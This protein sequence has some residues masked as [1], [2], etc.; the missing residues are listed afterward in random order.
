MEEEK[1]GKVYIGNDGILHIMVPELVTEEDIWEILEEIKKSLGGT[2]G[3]TK[4]LIHMKTTSVIKSSVFR[5][6]T[7][8]KIRNL[9]EKPG[10]GKA[11]I[12]GSNT[13]LRTIAK[14][15]VAASRVKN[16]RVFK[17][18]KEALRWLKE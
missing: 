5:K 15:I 13:V 7:A 4:I 11:A 2:L 3:E 12:F 9:A 18:E 14:F 6:I 17:T 8:N 16:I 10:Y 1:K